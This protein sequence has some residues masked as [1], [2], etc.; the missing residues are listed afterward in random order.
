MGQGSQVPEGPDAIKEWTVA[1]GLVLGD[2]GLLLVRNRRRNGAHDW[3]PPGGVIEHGEAIVAGLT[4]EVVEETGLEVSDWGDG[5]IYEVTV[6]A[7]DMGWRLHVEAH[8]ARAF[9]GE[10]HVDDPDGIVVE[11]AWVD[12]TACGVHLAEGH[13]W[14]REPVQAWLEGLDAWSHRTFRYHVAGNDPATVV[15]TYL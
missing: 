5:P 4:R 8:L 2:D 7:P 3:S 6:E 1:G 12:P 14:V 10:L 11:A 9:A 15:V 13:P